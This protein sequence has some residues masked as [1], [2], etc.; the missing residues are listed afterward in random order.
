MIGFGTVKAFVTFDRHHDRRLE[1]AALADLRQIRGRDLP[2]RGIHRHD[3]GAIL[4]AAVGALPV[5]QRR[6]G[7]HGK[8]DA[9]QG[10]IADHRRV[11]DDSNRLGVSGRAR[12]GLV[13]FGGGLAAA[14]IARFD[15]HDALHIGKDALDAPEASAREHGNRTLRLHCGIDGR[16]GELDDAFRLRGRALRQH[17]GSDQ[18][19]EGAPHH[20][21]I[22]MATAG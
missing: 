9:Q 21:Q 16:R 18:R 4:G 11:I 7:D 17:R 15:R 13:I 3:R 10:A 20:D 5:F 14:M 12:R 2:L 22:G 1:I 8:Q 6:V 19:G